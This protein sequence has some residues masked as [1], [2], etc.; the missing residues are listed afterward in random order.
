MALPDQLIPLTPLF[1]KW[2]D[3]NLAHRSETLASASN[4]DLRNLAA[5]VLPQVEAIELHLASFGEHPLDDAAQGLLLLVETT[6]DAVHELE[7][8]RLSEA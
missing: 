1:D 2:C 6:L 7:L 5:Q 4:D 8:R 3:P